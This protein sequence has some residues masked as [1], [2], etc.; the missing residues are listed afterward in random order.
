MVDD[1]AQSLGDFG[2]SF[3]GFLDQMAAQAPTS[4]AVFLALLKAHFSTDPSAF[5]IVGEDF[6]ASDHPNIQ[7]QTV[8]FDRHSARLAALQGSTEV[9]MRGGTT[10]PCFGWWT[11]NALTNHVRD[12][13]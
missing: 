8:G 13:G 10:S 11:G 3:K 6:D 9:S 5:P 4:E 7:R 12:L 1:E 2:A